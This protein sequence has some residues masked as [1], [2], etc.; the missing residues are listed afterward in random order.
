MKTLIKHV[1]PGLLLA[2]AATAVMA[3]TSVLVLE[4]S[5]L[6]EGSI[7]VAKDGTVQD[8]LVDN[9]ARYGAPIVELVRKTALRWRFEPIL[10]DGTPVTAKCS[11]HARVVLKKL[12]DGQFAASVKGATFGDD[13][14]HSTDNLRNTSHNKRI[15]P[16][17]PDFAVQNRV[18]GTVYLSVRVDRSGKVIDAAAE[19]VNLTG[20]GEKHDLR[21]Y[22]DALAGSAIKAAKRWI[23]KP[24][25]TGKLAAEESWSARVPVTYRLGTPRHEPVWKTY[26]PGPYTPAPWVDKPDANA[27]D[28]LADDSVQTDGA[29]PTLL[30]PLSHG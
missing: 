7:V 29:G 9:P 12:P 22:R 4:S 2:M 8:V 18:Q 21:R 19:Q 15:M 6:V 5:A 23:Y 25:T 30:S 1:M 10:L 17:Y 13:G 26:V 27:A 28:A 16:E 11:M 3:D 20:F 14:A 24:P